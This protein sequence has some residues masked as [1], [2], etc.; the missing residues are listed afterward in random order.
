MT[1]SLTTLQQL[2]PSLVS[3]VDRPLRQQLMGWFR[4]HNLA[5]D[6]NQSL[7][8]LLTTF[9]QSTAQSKTNWVETFAFFDATLRPLIQKSSTPQTQIYLAQ[10]DQL[11]AQ[12]T[13]SWLQAPG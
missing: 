8:R 13:Q 4:R 2:N 1:A 3:P 9:W 7:D 6:P 5:V 10:V 11:K 12:L